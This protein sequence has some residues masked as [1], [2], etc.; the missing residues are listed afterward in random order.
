MSLQKLNYRG[1][2]RPGEIWKAR[3]VEYE[4]KTGVKSRPIVIKSVDGDIVTYYRCT[5]TAGLPGTHHILD[6]ISAG[7]YKETYIV[8]RVEK[9]GLSRLAHRFGVLSK[10]DKVAIKSFPEA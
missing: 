2:P 5:S 10:F 6:N 3:N 9:I 1:I 4:D 8:P 7:L